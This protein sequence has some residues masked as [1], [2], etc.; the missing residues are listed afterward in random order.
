MHAPLLMN[1]T[2]A[3]R[4]DPSDTAAISAGWSAAESLVGRGPIPGPGSVVL[5]P[6]SLVVV[7]KGGGVVVPKNPEESS[8]DSKSSSSP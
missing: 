1:T 2:A 5:M 3:T 6:G 8:P 4:I 7:L